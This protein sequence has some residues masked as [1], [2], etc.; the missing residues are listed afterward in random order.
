MTMSRWLKI[1]RT[2]SLLYYDIVK[3]N[4]FLTTSTLKIV[5]EV[6]LN[7]KQGQAEQKHMNWHIQKR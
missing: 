2:D 1:I 7:Q 5:T 3:E 6:V 4:A